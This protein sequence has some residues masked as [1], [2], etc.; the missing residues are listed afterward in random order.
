MHT[1]WIYLIDKRC[2]TICFSLY[3]YFLICHCK[4]KRQALSSTVL[5]RDQF[6]RLKH[7]NYSTT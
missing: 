2:W 7:T 6:V 5:T 1:S 4:E 3:L